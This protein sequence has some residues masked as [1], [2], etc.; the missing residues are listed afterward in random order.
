MTKWWTRPVLLNHE[1]SRSDM[2]RCKDAPVLDKQAYTQAGCRYTRVNTENCASKV[3]FMSCKFLKILQFWQ[4]LYLIRQTETIS[5]SYFFKRLMWKYLKL[6][7]PGI[8]LCKWLLKSLWIVL[9]FPFR[10]LQVK[11]RL[12]FVQFF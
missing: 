7:I 10:H 8:L 11:C 12:Q 6:V 5:W 4:W 3:S 1:G 9:F 2:T